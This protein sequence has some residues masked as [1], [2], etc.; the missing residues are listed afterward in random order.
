MTAQWLSHY[1]KHGDFT[2]DPSTLSWVVPSISRVP[3][4]FN[5]SAA[6]YDSI[7]QLGAASDVDNSLLNN[8]SP[9]LHQ[10]YRN[11]I[12]GDEVKT[13]FPKLKKSL[14]TGDK[15]ASFGPYSYYLV[16]NDTSVAGDRSF[17]LKVVPGVNHFVSWPVDPSC[18]SFITRL[19]D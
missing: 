6:E 8:F 2:T 11:A 3:S 12:F 7:V 17:I 18:T 16:K 13:A 9:M 5:M 1:F 4:I 10:S 15:S 14:F 19:L